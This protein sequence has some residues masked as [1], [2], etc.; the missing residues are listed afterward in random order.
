MNAE[1]NDQK[2]YVDP[3][4]L[5]LGSYVILELS[6]LQHP[7]A[8]NSF[9]VRT[10][11]QLETIRALGLSRIRI[12][13][14][15]SEVGQTAGVASSTLTAE[16]SAGGAG[17]D[18]A[19]DGGAAA[20]KAARV[21]QNRALRSSIG[22]AEKQA[23]KAANVLRNVTK[24][25]F[26]SPEAAVESANG[27]V[28]SIAESLLGNS[29]VMVHLLNDKVAGEEVYFHSLNVT[30]LALLLGKAMGYDA[31]LLKTIG[32]AAIFHDIGKED[33]P[34]KILVK[35][36][37]LTHAEAEFLRQHCVIGARMAATAKLPE[38]VIAAILQHHERLDGSGYPEGSSGERISRIARLISVVN[39]YDNLCNPINASKALTPY[40]ALAIMF[41]RQK[42]W[43][44]PAMLGKLIHVLG[45]YP[46]GSVVTLSSGATAMVIS[47][48][49]ARPLRPTVIV[50][51]DG[52]PKE[53]AII[54]DLEAHPDI[55]ISK[56][57]RP[58]NLTRSVFEYLSPRRRMTYYFDD[59]GTPK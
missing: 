33:I 23:A 11:E 54:L 12:D 42:A 35:E 21:A 4:K 37:P 31:S 38:P 26:S 16:A 55:S 27:L 30:M 17:D 32:M 40:E 15:Q 25:I 57:V 39:S 13:P 58:G 52:I 47:V 6:W 50:H 22:A 29:E 20:E 8:F 51:D 49:P 19:D 36:E 1:L 10:E 53:E 56:A 24:Q 59:R 43:F 14:R 18:P 7:F 46:P 45:V 5:V 44:D 34:H 48:N 28:S 2:I 3:A 9:V 41:A